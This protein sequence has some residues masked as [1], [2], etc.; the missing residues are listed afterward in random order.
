MSQFLEFN[1]PIRVQYC[2]VPATWS[3]RKDPIEGTV[4]TGSIDPRYVAGKLGSEDAPKAS[5]VDPWEVRWKFLKVNLEDPQ[6]T[7]QFLNNV[8]L[9]GPC[10][11]ISARSK[12]VIEFTGED[13]KHAYDLRASLSKLRKN[14]LEIQQQFCKE[15][16]CN[17]KDPSMKD[18][19]TRLAW[20]EKGPT[21][22]ITAGS[23][24]D[25]YHAAFCIDQLRSARRKKCERRGCSNIFTFVGRRKRK[26]CSPECGHYVAVQNSRKPRRRKR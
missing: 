20:S 24:H 25:A 10:R 23:F 19:E 4:F 18:L 3:Y 13:G 8:G 11:L 17:L 14:D 7:V 9:F 5:E 21:L 2:C 15:W 26:Y 1:I 6:A 16:P 12:S 22:F